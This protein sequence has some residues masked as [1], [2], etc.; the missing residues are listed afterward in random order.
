MFSFSK[1][2]VRSFCVR[3]VLLL[4]G[5]LN[6]ILLA[7]VDARPDSFIKEHERRLENGI[8]R[9]NSGRH[10]QVLGN[11]NGHR[12]GVANGEETPD[13]GLGQGPAGRISTLFASRL[14]LVH[15]SLPNEHGKGLAE[16]IRPDHLQRLAD[17]ARELE[18]RDKRHAPGHDTPAER[19]DGGPDGGLLEGAAH[20]RFRHLLARNVLGLFPLEL[21][22]RRLVL[23][24]PRGRVLVPL[25][26]GGLLLFEF[27]HDGVGVAAAAA[28]AGRKQLGQ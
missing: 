20:G 2:F 3:S 18:R 26:E 17:A 10:G 9:S 13:Q 1:S 25:A 12:E 23:R 7:P 24:Q 4:N 22:Q 14:A 8:R 19:L 27:P 11:E 6:Q 5:E 21:L 28:A 16:E 15:Q